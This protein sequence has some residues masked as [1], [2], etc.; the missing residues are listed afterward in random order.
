[1]YQLRNLVISITTLLL[2]SLRRTWPVLRGGVAEG[3]TGKW[4][5]QETRGGGAASRRWFW[6][7]AERHKRARYCLPLSPLC[8]VEMST[9]QK[10]SD[11]R[12]HE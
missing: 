3:R 8:F 4:T 2:S 7:N 9:D 6:Q 12:Y 5:T 11:W 10:K 1:M